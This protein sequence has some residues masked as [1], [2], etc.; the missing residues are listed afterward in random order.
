MAI[1]QTDAR[2][3]SALD[4]IISSQA[5]GSG[6]RLPSLLKY[7]LSEEIAGRGERIKAFSIA[8]TVFGRGSDFDPQTDSI[9]RVEMARL[10]KALQLFNATEGLE[11]PL[12]IEIPKGSYRPVIVLKEPESSKVHK[13]APVPATRHTPPR[14]ALRVG[15]VMLAVMAAVGA[16]IAIFGTRPAQIDN[17]EARVV[18][19]AVDFT[20]DV[21]GYEF[22]PAGLRSD[23][24][25][26]LSVYR[27]FTVSQ[28]QAR[29]DTGRLKDRGFN[30][31]VYTISTV[32]QIVAGS[33]S[34]RA[35]LA[36]G[37]EQ[38]IEW[39]QTYAQPID[40]AGQSA[41]SLARDVAIRIAADI[42]RPMGPISKTELQRKTD[43]PG[44]ND[45]RYMCLL[46][47][48]DYWR[49]LSPEGERRTRLCLDA[50]IAK[51][52]RFS[53]G[54]AALSFLDLDKLRTGRFPDQAGALLE[55]A[56]KQ[57]N[58]A[59]ELQ[60]DDELPLLA[61][62]TVAACA[63]DMETMH[64]KANLLLEA[65]PRWP[66]VLSD[67]GTKLAIISGDW[68]RGLDLV[69]KANS[70]NSS[71]EPWY[72][73]APAIRLIMDRKPAEA[74]L[75]LGRG[76]QR[77][78][79]QGHLVRLVASQLS[80]NAAELAVARQDLLRLGYKDKADAKA[81]LEASCWSRDVINTLKSALELG[82]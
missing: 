13:A 76:S 65:Y 72:G 5:F 8:T 40:N 47:F 49:N 53:D 67:V 36:G 15:A 50:A 79:E 59:F 70:F 80:G 52:P 75:L 39:S 62:M 69:K 3:F 25:A 77:S 81:L 82:Y 24:A 14:M 11:A 6:T 34:V 43:E 22:I 68:S 46:M 37:P 30:E 1:K 7:L 10:R 41:L 26:K 9:V 33:L 51:Y 58:A 20:S 44:G 48:R 35:T 12:Q 54:L 61:I 19:N 45:Q 23:I 28:S 74:L 78:F 21:P 55:L 18:V 56:G 60:P 27:W 38:K 71:P 31:Q 63:G 64:R 4:T 32:A 57:A 73:L 66:D 29:R 2:I 16:A 17:K 42:G